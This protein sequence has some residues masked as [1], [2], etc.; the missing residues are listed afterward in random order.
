M[1]EF[2]PPPLSPQNRY[3][4]ISLCDVLSEIPTESRRADGG[5]WE[6]GRA[7]EMNG[8]ISCPML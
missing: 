7:L 5:V 6:D 8:G 1:R 4:M 3:C 2:M